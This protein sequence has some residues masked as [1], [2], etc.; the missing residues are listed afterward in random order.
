MNEKNVE[1]ILG[2]D[3][4]AN[5]V[6]WAL[7]EYVNGTPQRI[8]G[9]GS[10]IFDAAVEGNLEK[11]QEESR[12]VERRMAR[13]L[14]RQHKR[15]VMR[16]IRVGELL[17]QAGWL[18]A[19]NLRDSVERDRLFKEL[20][21]ALREQ[22]AIRGFKPSDTDAIR[23]I[24]YFLRAR[25]L[26]E[27]LQPYALGRALYHLAARRGFLSNRKATAKK[28]EDL[29]EVKK[30][31]TELKKQI[32]E[33]GARTLGEYFY[34]HVDPVKEKRIRKRWTAREMYQDEFDQI[35]ARQVELGAIQ[36]NP[37]F[38]RKLRK[39]IF[40]QR[41]LKSQRGLIGPCQFEEKEKR[42]PWHSLL[43]QEF[44]LLQK[45][46]DLKLISPNYEERSLT[47]EERKVL[48]DLL[49]EEESVSFA[50]LGK[51]LG[52]K[53]KDGWRFN[54]EAGKETKLKGNEVAA[55]LIKVFGR[56]RW[57]IMSD[58]EKY[59][60]IS[61]LNSDIT[62]K[63]LRRR[64][65]EVWGLNDP[66]KVDVL[67]KMSLP[68]GY[69]ALSRKALKKL[70][71]LMRAG[72]P[73]ETAVRETYGDLRFKKQTFDRLPPFLK[74]DHTLRSPVVIRTL[75]ETRKV[76]NEIIR[77]FGRPDRIHLEL[78]REMKQ[79]KD[80]RK[81]RASEMRDRQKQ[82]EMAIDGIQKC[83]GIDRH[84]ISRRDVD[85]WLLAE[86]CGWVCPYS[87]RPINYLNLFSST[88]EFDIE[89]IIPYSKSLDDS[90][91]NKTLCHREWNQRKGNRTPAQAFKDTPEWE[92]MLQRVRSFKP[93]HAV[94]R[95]GS[96]RGGQNRVDPYVQSKLHR[97]QME[98]IPR[99]FVDQKLNDTRHAAKV[100]RAYL[101]LLYPPEERLKRVK[102][103]SGAVTAELRKC[104]KLN[105]ILGDPESPDPIK[106]RADHRHHAIDAL[107]LALATQGMVQYLSNA[108]EK[109][110]QCQRSI[111][112]YQKWVDEP[113]L[114][115]L[116][117]VRNAVAA[118][119]VSHRVDH[120]IQG[121]LH[122]E[123]FYSPPRQDENGKTY[124]LVR[125]PLDGSFDAGKVERI[126]DRAVREIV[127]K[128]LEDHGNDPK[129]A[130][131]EPANHPR[132][133][134]IP[135]HSVRIRDYVSPIPVGKE[136]CPRYVLT[137]SNHHMEIIEEQD[138]K[139]NPVWKA[140]VVSRY[141]A[142]RR[143]A[144][145]QPVVQRDHG[146]G[147]RFVCSIASGDTF[148]FQENGGTVLAIA[149]S[150][151]DQNIEFVTINDARLK[152]DIK[153]AGDWKKR[154]VNAF[155]TMCF[156]KVMISPVGEVY[157]A[158]D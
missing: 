133:N 110:L 68:A 36:D 106:N 65:V 27:P 91:A 150:I 149:R 11:G 31:I 108:V 87:G 34:H 136:F 96:S 1:K 16:M 102:A 158:H 81:K 97:F 41:P 55:R 127:R 141:E 117:D 37:K 40:R 5:S 52:F 152:A 109:Q 70:V 43:A 84:R 128:H 10:R 114:D 119:V 156:Q 129:K 85:K 12:A 53:P 75:S 59:Q 154:S 35:L 121:R 90:F 80:R 44:R 56:D 94:N 103:F 29:G 107:V 115:F 143:K 47:D 138:R 69:C 4:G 42:A 61:E 99:D 77:V 82:R 137:D 144:S 140:V 135:I 21:K 45:I 63:T 124:H 2:L 123:T 116:N 89:H 86:E 66:E 62:D 155:R 64:A 145:G 50:D 76:V 26:D 48:Y 122:N 24:A 49:M 134:N 74:I 7:I 93:L 111:R 142:M 22:Y 157:P 23:G 17:Q 19:G 112:G 15:R 146:E 126:E 95:P 132:I 148:S 39:A 73:Y 32:E 131:N 130:F 78:A 79:S 60:L 20:D 101:E 125:K 118:I 6:G 58:R 72:M 147:K 88:P 92:A 8:V 3:L 13:Q 120:R 83:T 9:M 139:G 25:A 46:N 54:L 153:K 104:W 67:V 113:W 14:R 30:G 28:D 98:E 105:S 71:P 38:F 151:S 33:K 57:L 100:A 18:P 51:R